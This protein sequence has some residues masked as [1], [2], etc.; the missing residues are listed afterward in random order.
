MSNKL[1]EIEE[2]KG[3]INKIIAA[4]VNGDSRYLYESQYQRWGKIEKD[5]YEQIDKHFASLTAEVR[6]LRAENRSLRAQRK[7]TGLVPPVMIYKGDRY[8]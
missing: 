3:A 4:V 1:E 6:Q 5:I 2:L 7:P 8:E